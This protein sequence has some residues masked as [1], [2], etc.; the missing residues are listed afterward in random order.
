MKNRS[1]YLLLLL[2][3]GLLLGCASVKQ[4]SVMKRLEN[5]NWV[6]QFP[7]PKV[8][9][10]MQRYV[11]G[12]QV[13]SLFYV[14]DKGYYDAKG[15]ESTDSCSYYLSDLPDTIFHSEHVGKIVDGKC[16]VT[17]RRRDVGSLEILKLT[18]DSLVVKSVIRPGVLMIGGGY[19]V[20]YKALSGRAWERQ[21]KQYV[22][23]SMKLSGTEHRILMR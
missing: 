4:P 12:V 18:S 11:K 23:S 2:G 15:V 21:K 22:R 16:I 1:A 6:V 20:T 19:P 7:S 9:C 13:T 8:L 10:F 3:M 14:K 17:D 5:K